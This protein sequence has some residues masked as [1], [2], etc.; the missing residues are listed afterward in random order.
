[1][2]GKYRQATD[3]AMN[4]LGLFL[5][6][7]QTAGVVAGVASPYLNQAIKENTAPNSTAN[8]I[9]HGVLGAVEMGLQGGNAGVGAMSAMAGEVSA[10]VIA[11]HLYAAKDP[12]SLTESQKETVSQLSQLVGA[13]ISGGASL[14]TGGNSYTTM[15]S[16]DLGKNIAENAVENNY[17]SAQEAERKR[18]LEDKLHRGIITSEE[19]TELGAINEKDRQSDIA[20]ISACERNRLSMECHVERQKLERDKFSYSNSQYTPTG[21]NYPTYTRYSEMYSDEYDKVA[22]FSDRYDV[23]KNAKVKA[24]A[25]FYKKTGIDPSWIGRVDVANHVIASIAGTKLSTTQADK[26]TQSVPKGVSSNE[27]LPVVSPI[28]N[29]P[30]GISF[31]INLK[32]HLSVGEE[33][34]FSQKK[35]VIGVHNRDNFYDVLSQNG[36][37]VI[38]EDASETKGISRITYEIPRLGRDGKP[39]GTYKEINSPKTVYDPKIYSDEKILEWGQDAATRNYK[40][41][42]GLKEYN[43]NIN[44][45]EFRIYQNPETGEI[46]NVHPK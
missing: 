17:L 25:E 34:K 11:E 4:A 8:L 27:K 45:I 31:S 42:L 37:R 39:D 36:G 29:Y 10:A 19:I 21:Y 30:E 24:D 20:L 16:A 6:G 40:N 32:N 3:A 13:S 28:A 43:S 1:M 44:N 38:R 35:G 23:L 33:I 18:I 14:A 41:S 26:A 12:S 9:A 5:G 7:S 46:R 22:S 2:G 15:K